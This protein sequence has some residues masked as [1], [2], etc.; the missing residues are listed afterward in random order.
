MPHP[1]VIKRD[2]F[3]RKLNKNEPKS[4]IIK[5]DHSKDYTRK[6]VDVD[7]NN[8]AQ[9]CVSFISHISTDLTEDS[10]FDIIE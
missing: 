1:I 4:I 10:D 7:I 8:D 3:N 9:S 5:S 6:Y 2:V